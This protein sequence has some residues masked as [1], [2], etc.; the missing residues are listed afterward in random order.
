MKGAWMEEAA[1]LGVDPELF[2]REHDQHEF[3]Q[4]SSRFAKAVCATCPVAAEC[5]AHALAL[6]ARYGIFGGLSASERGH[7]RRKAMA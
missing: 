7:A 2:F 3:G 4:L 5:L 1:C 6:D